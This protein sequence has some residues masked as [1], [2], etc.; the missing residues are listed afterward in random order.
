MA[1]GVTATSGSTTQTAAPATAPAP[2]APQQVVPFVRG[3]GR[4]AFSIKKF[5]GQA[6]TSVTQELDA[7]VKAYGYMRS[8]RLDVTTTAAGGATGTAQPDA[9]FNLFAGIT[10][11]QPNQQPLYSVSSGFHAAMIQKYGLLQAFNDPRA[12]PN[13]QV[14]GS[15]ATFSLQ[16]PFEVDTRDGL[17]SLPNK[18]AAAPYQIAVMLNTLTNVF[19]ASQGTSPTFTEDGKYVIFTIAQSKADEEKDKAAEEATTPVAG[20]GAALAALAASAFVRIFL[21]IC[22]LITPAVSAAAK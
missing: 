3:S 2:Q 21:H 1:A 10:V 22:P 11:A 8:I 19:G 17:G 4:N 18:N 20:A 5:T 15:W 16:I 13:F 14:N 6:L 9:P 7:D 12:D